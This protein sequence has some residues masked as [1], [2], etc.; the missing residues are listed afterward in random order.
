MELWEALNPLLQLNMAWYRIDAPG[1]I[2]AEQKKA[3]QS[4]KK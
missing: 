4:K 3:E 1:V 2:K